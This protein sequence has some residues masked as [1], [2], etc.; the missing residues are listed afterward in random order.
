MTLGGG[1]GRRVCTVIVGPPNLQDNF[2]V[3]IEENSVNVPVDLRQE[4]AGFPEPTMFTWY[5]GGQELSELAQT[6]FSVTFD[7][8]TRTDAGNYTV[9]ATNFILNSTVEQVGSD[10]GSFYLDVV[11][12]LHDT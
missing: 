1:G 12:K 2:R 7:T 6:F 10:T 11:C 4:P 5:R 9:T 8:I 3:M